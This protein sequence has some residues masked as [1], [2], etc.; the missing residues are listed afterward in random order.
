MA[1]ASSTRA[2]KK[3]WQPRSIHDKPKRSW[4]QRPAPSSSSEDP[5]FVPVATSSRGAA[6]TG[7][8]TDPEDSRGRKRS[9]RAAARAASKPQYPADCYF[10]TRSITENTKATYH[11]AF[12]SFVNFCDQESRPALPRADLASADRALELYFDK[13]FFDGENPHVGETLIAAFGYHTRWSTKGA[14][15]CAR[16]QRLEGDRSRPCS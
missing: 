4:V 5:L 12:W 9:Q 14:L 3:Q 15:P 11:D 2:G 1:L 16:S 6:R 10:R 8:W 13:L 7:A